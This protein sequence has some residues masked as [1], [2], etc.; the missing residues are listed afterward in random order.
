M[1]KS[2]R[3][4]ATPRVR[5]VVWFIGVASLVA[6]LAI[7]GMVDFGLLHFPYDKPVV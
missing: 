4:T 6:A 2:V 3:T 1:R 5:R 7:N